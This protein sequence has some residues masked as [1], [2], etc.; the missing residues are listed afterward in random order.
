MGPSKT[1]E[2][3]ADDSSGKGL[4]E[5]ILVHAGDHRLKAGPFR[6]SVSREDAARTEGG[7]ARRTRTGFFVDSQQRVGLNGLAM[8]A[9]CEFS[10]FSLS[11]ISLR[12]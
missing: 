1:K 12:V 5:S 2:I 9:G 6:S 8:A 3:M 10:S 4:V 7:A 11:R